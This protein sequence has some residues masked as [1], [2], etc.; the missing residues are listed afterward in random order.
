MFFVSGFLIS[1]VLST[2]KDTL[3]LSNNTDANHNKK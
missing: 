3:L 2:N 1:K